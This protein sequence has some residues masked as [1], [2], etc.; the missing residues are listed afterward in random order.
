VLTF[1]LSVLNAG[2][3]KAK[4]SKIRFYL[5]TDRVLNLKEETYTDESGETPVQRT[6]PKD[7]PL[8]IGGR[9]KEVNLI[10]LSPGMGGG[11]PFDLTPNGDSRIYLPKGESGMGYHLIV[12]L[13]YDDPLANLSPIAREEIVE[14]LP[15]FS[16]NPAVI[17]VTETAGAKHTQ[18]FEVVLDR[19]PNAP[20]TIPLS[21]VNSNGAADTTEFYFNA[22]LPVPPEDDPEL[23]S[24]R[25]LVSSP[26]HSVTFTPEMWEQ[27]QKKFTIQVT[28]KQD[29]ARDGDQAGAVRIGPSISDDPRFH[30]KLAR[31]LTVIVRD[32]DSLISVPTTSLVTTEEEGNTHS[33]TFVVRLTKKPTAD[34][35]V[36]VVN[37]DESEGTVTSDFLSTIEGKPSLRFTP[38]ETYPA[39]RTIT[40]TAVDDNVADGTAVYTIEIG[41]SVSEDV[42]FDGI[43]PPNVI[44]TNLD[45]PPDN[46]G[47]DDEED[48]EDDDGGDGGEG[49]DGNN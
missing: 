35:I 28:G 31:M 5:S 23:P 30:G 12:A 21:V 22:S 42:D 20:V 45:N 13:V 29:E 25:N 4:P 38:N 7:I 46:S 37:K 10:A 6:R 17:E 15:P 32:R 36:P 48:D 41:P 18:T 39:S 40:V 34:V 33:R 3:K 47:G 19:K 9:D 1:N 27:G 16:P 49:G 26:D 14:V 44:V 8:L 2:N 11:I 24:D 43:K